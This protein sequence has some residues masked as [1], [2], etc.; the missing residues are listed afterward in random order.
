[1]LYNTI[2]NRGTVSLVFRSRGLCRSIL[3][4]LL[5]GQLTETSWQL[6][7][8]SNSAQPSLCSRQWAL[9]LG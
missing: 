2:P 3:D 8:E 4:P 7:V 9:W 1:M 5:M 6:L